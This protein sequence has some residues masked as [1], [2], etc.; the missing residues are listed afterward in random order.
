MVQYAV[1]DNTTLALSGRR[2]YNAG[3]GAMALTP[4]GG[5]YYYY[6]EE[7]VDTNEMSSRSGFDGGN[8]NLNINLFYNDYDGY[9]ASNSLRRIT[10]ID[11]AE[12]YGLEMEFTSMLGDSYNFLKT[13]LR[14]VFHLLIVLLPKLKFGSC[15]RLL[16]LAQRL[17]YLYL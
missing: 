3:G 2:G 9:Q 12:T 13:R 6:D 15:L 4:A 10:N 7:S 5:E 11:K 14:F 17:L 8:I 1:S 16:Y